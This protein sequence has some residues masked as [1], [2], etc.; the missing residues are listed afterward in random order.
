[1]VEFQVDHGFVGGEIA[2][3]IVNVHQIGVGV[4]AV[5]QHLHHIIEVVVHVFLREHSAFGIVVI[6]QIGLVNLAVHV[7]GVVRVSV[8]SV[9]FRVG[10]HLYHG[11]ERLVRQVD[12]VVGEAHLLGHSFRG[13]CR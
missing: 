13:S 7:V 3:Q 12:A 6:V 4:S 10:V 8:V 11:G 1:M 9:H 5:L 2:C